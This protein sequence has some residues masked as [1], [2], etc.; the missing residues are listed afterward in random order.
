MQSVSGLNRTEQIN[1]RWFLFSPHLFPCPT[2]RIYAG[3]AA[4]TQPFSLSNFYLFIMEKWKRILKSEK[5][6]K[7]EIP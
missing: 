6:S 7:G 1:I 4:W 5:G 2:L 3:Q